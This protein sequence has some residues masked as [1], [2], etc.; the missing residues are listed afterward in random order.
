M[1]DS[2]GSRAADAP[3]SP[4]DDAYR[5]H[6]IGGI[7]GN[8]A[9]AGDRSFPPLTKLFGGNG[10]A[11]QTNPPLPTANMRGAEAYAAAKRRCPAKRDAAAQLLHSGSHSDEPIIRAD[12]RNNA[13][14]VRARAE[15]MPSLA[16]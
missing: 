1:T 8:P 4:G 6:D 5:M 7:G 16:S 15:T 13:I 11:R 12:A 10:A 3:A 9:A 2:P 14:L